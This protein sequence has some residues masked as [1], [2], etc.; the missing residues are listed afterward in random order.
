MWS[1]RGSPDEARLEQTPYPFH[2]QPIWRYSD[3]IT[4]YRFN[5]GAHT[6]AWAQIGAGAEPPWPPHFNHWLL[7]LPSLEARRL[8][9]DLIW[10]YKIV[11]GHTIT[12]SDFF[13]FRLSN[14]PHKSSVVAVM[15]PGLRFF[16]SVWL[17][18]GIVCYV[19]LLT[20]ICKGL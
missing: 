20:F 16:Q 1:S 19:M 17:M 4:L 9:N 11:F 13:E 6:I 7:L 12:Y 10:C 2:N 15:L 8:Q 5:Q 18:F 3:I 14:T